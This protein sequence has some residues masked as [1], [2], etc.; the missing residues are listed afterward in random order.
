MSLIRS[1]T[2]NLA[3]RFLGLMLVAWQPFTSGARLPSVLLLLLGLWLLFHKRIDLGALATRR[4][5]VVFLLL[6]VPVLISLPTSYN[7]AGTASVAIALVL[8]FVVGLCLMYGLRTKDDHAWLQRWLTIVLAIWLAD[9]FIQYGFG[10]DL[11]GVPMGSDGR[12]MGPFPDNLHF[13]LFMTVLLPIMLWR[14]TKAYPL[15]AIACIALIGFVAGISGA[16]SNVLFYLLGIA[17]LLPRFN[18]R[19]RAFILI[20]L[21]VSIVAAITQ[22]ET[23]AAKFRQ[24]NVASEQSLFQKLDHMLSGRMTIW[25]TAFEMLKDRPLAGVGAGAF[26]DAY[27]QYATRP[28]DPFRSGGSYPGGVYHAHQMYVSIAAE[29]GFIGL[30]GLLAAIGLLARW[31]RQAESELRSRAAPYAAS[32]IVIAFP[33]QSQPVLYRIWWFPVVLLLLSGFIIALE[34]KKA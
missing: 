30:A 23:I 31:Y 6:L 8:F 19:H 34:P 9:G 4:L 16:R 10:Y 12:I 3:A 14:I 22:S 28:E 2:P 32:L 29:S 26:D 1:I 27:D 18:W 11:L 17:T 25:E 7:P 13:G 15:V 20:A 33:L 21:V 5:A 24:F